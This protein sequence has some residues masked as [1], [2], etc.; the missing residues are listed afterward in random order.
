MG[1]EREAFSLRSLA[2]R[3]HVDRAII[4][5]LVRSGQLPAARIGKRRLL[6]LRRDWEAL[7]RRKA[8]RPDSNT[9]RVVEERL[10]REAAS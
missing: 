9:V 3:Y 10:K 2:R 5:E 7:L 8:I 4:S 6:V 1:E